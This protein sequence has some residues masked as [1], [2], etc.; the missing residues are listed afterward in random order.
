MLI[1]KGSSIAR[2]RSCIFN[3]SV[4]V[5]FLLEAVVAKSRFD[6]VVGGWYGHM[7]L[8]I[9][10]AIVL[11]ILGLSARNTRLPTM[12]PPRPVS[13]VLGATLA[14]AIVC[15]VV[16]PNAIANLLYLIV[17]AT[18]IYVCLYIAPGLLL[19]YLRH[20][21]VFVYGLLLFVVSLVNVISA[22]S[23]D[24]GAFSEGR[25]QGLLADPLHAGTV[26]MIT[27]ILI[28]WA[29]LQSGGRRWY[30][31][32]AWAVAMCALVMTRT[33]SFIFGC[34]IGSL[35]LLAVG[36]Q[37][38]T[39][40]GRYARELAFV[41]LLATITFGIVISYSPNVLPRL[42]AHLRIEGD[43]EEILEGR[44]IHWQLGVL[45]VKAY[46]I[47][48]RGPMA[49]FGNATDPTV[50]TYEM[51]S[52]FDNT[53][54][55]MAQSYGIPGSALFAASVLAMLVLSLRGCGTMPLLAVGL[56]TAGIG[57]SF[58]SMWAVSFGS[59]GDRA[60][61]LILGLALATLRSQRFP[62]MHTGYP[63][64]EKRRCGA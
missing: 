56:L 44:M 64:T 55:T 51:I 49:K 62:Y 7:V 19:P 30:L 54:L 58:S 53:W 40:S 50:N 47:F 39:A 3:A 42:R 48:G 22:L 1:P 2:S 37:R 41:F 21:S 24:G 29:I 5:A 13:I 59:G 10:F 23:G 27:S 20:R 12:P 31:W 9:L 63:T 46:P 43:S 52:C 17:F 60:M 16:Q 45:H 6:A 33:R 11:L 28:L 35:A 32:P 57:S 36:A 8:T 26:A 34:T 61:W 38:H 25:L 14:W 4:L 15:C 18:N